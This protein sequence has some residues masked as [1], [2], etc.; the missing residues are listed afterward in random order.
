MCCFVIIACCWARPRAA[1]AEHVTEAN[2]IEVLPLL[3]ILNENDQHCTSVNYRSRS[4]FI[5]IVS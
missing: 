4:C 3:N 1:F 2:D 5:H